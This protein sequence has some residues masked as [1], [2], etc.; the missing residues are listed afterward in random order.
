[1]SRICKVLIV[2]DDD[3][4]RSM[5]GD[6]F[7]AEGFEFAA[8]RTGGEMRAALAAGGYDIAVIDLLLP[9]GEDGYSLA[10][11]ARRAGCGVI[12]TTG[13]H[14]HEARLKASGDRYLLKPFAMRDLIG[15]AQQIL[16]EIEAMCVRRSA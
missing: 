13:D 3:S 14:R 2:E 1:M 8:V 5:L 4:V 12:L 11:S 16:D 6:L 10:A 15:L 9:G 7:D